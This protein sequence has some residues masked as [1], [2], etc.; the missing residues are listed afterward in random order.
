MLNFTPFIFLKTINSTREGKAEEVERK[1]LLNIH[2]CQHQKVYKL[3][4]SIVNS[5]VK[6]KL[7]PVAAKNTEFAKTTCFPASSELETNFCLQ[8]FH[9]Q[10]AVY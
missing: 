3:L 8:S 7:W 10:E 2:V 1:I 9:S 5:D 6:T 4:I